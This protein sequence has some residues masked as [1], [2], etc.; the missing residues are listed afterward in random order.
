MILGGGTCTA[1]YCFR[2][3]RKRHIEKIYET[4]TTYHPVYN[5]VATNEDATG[6]EK[7]IVNHVSVEDVE[8]INKGE[9]EE[10]E[11]RVEKINIAAS[12]HDIL[13]EETIPLKIEKWT[14]Q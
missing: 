3:R 12:P 2:R 7:A 5:P 8:D 1:C 10:P 6:P 4:V 9:D 11:E 14:M 13:Y